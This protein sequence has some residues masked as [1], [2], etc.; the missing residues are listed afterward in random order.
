MGVIVRLLVFIAGVAGLL[1]TGLNGAQDFGVDTASLLASLGETP[2]GVANSA[3]GAFGS[4]LDQLGGMIA[5]LTGAEADPENPGLV[6]QWAPAGIAAVVS[7]LM[8]MFSM[9][10]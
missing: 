2:G 5:N 3:T 6:Q 9:R 8:V 1:L 7:L 4:G 10:R